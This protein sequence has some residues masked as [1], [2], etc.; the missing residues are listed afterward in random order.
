M[1]DLWS[2][3]VPMI[4]GSAL[5]PVQIIITTMVLRSPSGRTAG[6][7]WLAGMTIVRLGQG[8]LFGLILGAAA[9]A[10][11]DGTASTGPNTGASLLLL[12]I[13]ILFLLT[14]AR[15]ALKQ[16]DE[17]APPPRWMAMVE[18]VTPVKA[19]GLGAAILLIGVKPWVF[20]LGAIN[21]IGAAGL[22]QGAAIATYLVFVL[23]AGSI[24]LVVVGL[25]FAMPARSASM[26]DAIATFM[27]RHSRVLMM[28]LGLVFGSWFLL[29]ALRGLGLL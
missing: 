28:V 12:V 22:G 24:N 21:A 29:K 16:P 14:A 11:G 10:A 1:A 13:A 26:V 7:A 15:Y 5:V 3:L 4:I 18:S 17:D 20:T 23:L 9:D 6:I 25:A 8:V 27:A 19:F 2:S